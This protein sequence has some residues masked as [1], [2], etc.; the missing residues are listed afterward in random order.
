LWT[1]AVVEVLWWRH[2]FR[3][4]P[5]RW[6]DE[7]S[8]RIAAPPTANIDVLER[9]LK[10][11]YPGRAMREIEPES[12]FDVAKPLPVYTVSLVDAV[13]EDWPEKARQVSWRHLVAGGQ[14]TGAAD[15]TLN[16]GSNSPE[17]ASFAEGEAVRALVTAIESAD[18]LFAHTKGSYEM[19]IVEIPAVY[20]A[21]VWLV[22][23]ESLFIPYLDGRSP[24]GRLFDVHPNYVRHVVQLAK[25]TLE[26]SPVP[27]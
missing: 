12:T 11:L 3:R 17:F 6:E 24:N 9:G 14:L 15:I 16:A 19:R 13:T 18:R 23:T 26:R 4:I 1:E 27:G 10:D 5:N 8:I 7:V 25:R 21:A 20:A 2:P 22:G